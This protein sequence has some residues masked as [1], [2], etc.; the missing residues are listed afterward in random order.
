MLIARWLKNLIPLGLEKL[1]EAFTALIDGL[2]IYT[3]IYICKYL[4]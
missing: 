4:Y 2:R 3:S 1:A